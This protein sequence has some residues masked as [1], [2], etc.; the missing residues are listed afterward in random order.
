MAARRGRRFQLRTR[1]LAGVLAVT[2]V[3]FAAFDVVAITDLHS[4][5]V[6]RV[7]ATL[8]NL[9]SVTDQHLDGLLGR[10]REGRIAPALEAGLG[11][12][13]YLAFVPDHGRPIVLN[14]APGV[15]PELP[16]NLNLLAA[17]HGARTVSEVGGT[18]RVRLRAQPVHGGVVVATAGLDE[19]HRTTSKLRLIMLVGSAI[20]VALIGL[21]VIVLVSRGLRPLEEMAAEADRITAGDLTN[22]VGPD[23]PASEVG[24]LAT[25]LNGMLARIDAA[26]QERESG[27]ELMRRFF[28]DASHELRNPLAS[29]RANADLYQQGA[30]PE[31]AQVDEAMRRIS[32]EA[33]RMSRLVDDMLDLARLDQHPDQQRATV[34]LTVLLEACAE[35]ARVTDPERT[36]TDHIERGLITTGDAEL[37]RRGVD[38]L[39]ANIRVHTPP[40]SD[41][42]LSAAG[43]HGSIEVTVSDTGPGVPADRLPHIF[44]RFYRA[45]PDAR[46]AGSGL[47]LAI[48]SEIARAHHGSV[49]ASPN[50]PQG[51]RVTLTLPPADRAAGVSAD[52]PALDDRPRAW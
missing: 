26:V 5:L 32:L 33:E 22:R 24:R 3:A 50:H 29:L 14:A 21:G 46:H 6:G 16:S 2:I 48:V 15:A 49:A 41:A 8:G 10:S 28:A 43:H 13:N 38:N 1:V 52:W 47:G 4:Y 40:G 42:T 44:D 30:L 25:A 51:L 35:R 17:D 27:Q 7:D 23:D 45:D 34:D 11:A 9:L 39:L 31:G 37:I 18:E 20:A 36:W 19:V 12:Y